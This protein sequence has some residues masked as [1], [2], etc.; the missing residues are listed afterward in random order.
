MPTVTAAAPATASDRP[1]T[2]PLARRR[3]AP[4]DATTGISIS[5][6][7]PGLVLTVFVH[8]SVSGDPDSISLE[9]RAPW[10]RRARPARAPS[11][12]NVISSHNSSLRVE[13]RRD[14]GIGHDPRAV[15]RHVLICQASRKRSSRGAVPLGGGEFAL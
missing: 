4:R 6:R 7:S 1:T 12:R 3:T 15:H 14:G 11:I 8:R 10:L 13:A 2:R 5:I 9:R